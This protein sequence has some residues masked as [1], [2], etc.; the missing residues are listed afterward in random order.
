M[1]AIQITQFGGPEVMKYV[2][3]PD[4]V[5][6]GEDVVMDVTAIGINYADTHQTGFVFV[7]TDFAINSRNGSSRQVTEWPTCIGACR[8]RRLLPEN[9]GK[10]KTS[11]P[12]T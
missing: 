3:L 9:F 6:S 2:D 11:Y 4:P 1:K 8:R 12:V 10:S 5:A 7:Q